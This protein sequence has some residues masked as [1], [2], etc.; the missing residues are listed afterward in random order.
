MATIVIILVSLAT[1]PTKK[2][3]LDVVYPQTQPSELYYGK[4]GEALVTVI[5]D[6]ILKL[7]LESNGFWNWIQT[8]ETLVGIDLTSGQHIMKV[9]GN[10]I[11]EFNIKHNTFATFGM[12]NKNHLLLAGEQDSLVFFTWLSLEG[13]QV[14][15]L[16]IEIEPVFRLYTNRRVFGVISQGKPVFYVPKSHEFIF[17]E[18]TGTIINRQKLRP[19]SELDRFS[20][21]VW[22]KLI[23]LEESGGEPL[24]SFC[25]EQKGAILRQEATAFFIKNRLFYI[26]FSVLEL[27]GWSEI[28]RMAKAVLVN[29]LV[30]YDQESLE[31]ANFHRIGPSETHPGGYQLRGLHGE[32]LLLHYRDRSGQGYVVLPFP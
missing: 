30:A 4:D 7:D 6:S 8:N 9:T 17:F 3:P 10:Q 27:Q 16:D 32:D 11:A 25:K 29:Y 14:S 22:E 23:G 28:R 20:P 12:A 19:P 1:G 24:I 26:N 13:G 2:I 31:L 21:A 5:D 18:D 15:S